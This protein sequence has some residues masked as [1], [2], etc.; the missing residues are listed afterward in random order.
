MS[1]VQ[2][3]RP[4]TLHTVAAALALLLSLAGNSSA[5]AF[6]ALRPS[7]KALSQKIANFLQGQKEKTIVVGAFTGPARWPASAGPGIKA[8]LIEELQ[9]EKV[10]IV[11]DAK[12]EVKGDYRNVFDDR[13]ELL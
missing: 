3:I 12:L 6:E 10:Q 1:L 4:A 13:S 8:M 7:L 5:H 2:R 9:K 11:R